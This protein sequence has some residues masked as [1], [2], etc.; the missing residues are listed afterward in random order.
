[1]GF[2]DRMLAMPVFWD[3]LG[4]LFSPLYCY[5]NPKSKITNYRVVIDLERCIDCGISVGRCPGYAKVLVRILKPDVEKTNNKWP[6]MGVFDE[7]TYEYVKKLV[8]LCPEEALII[9][10]IEKI[11]LLNNS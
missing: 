3:K 8:G 7:T 5:D 11:K 9:E 10:K 6:S 2:S 4:F 1:M